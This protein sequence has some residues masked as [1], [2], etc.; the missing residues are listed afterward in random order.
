M[1]FVNVKQAR[2]LLPDTAKFTIKLVNILV[3]DDR[4][5]KIFL[6]KDV[7]ILNYKSFKL[8]KSMFFKMM[9]SKINHFTKLLTYIEDKYIVTASDKKFTKMLKI[10]EQTRDGS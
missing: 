4:N 10:N 5:D 1:Q 6:D 8:R 3:I 2:Q 7:D 9:E